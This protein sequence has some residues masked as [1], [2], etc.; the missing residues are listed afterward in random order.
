MTRS[1]TGVQVAAMVLF[2]LVS[3]VILVP[4]LLLFVGPFRDPIGIVSR[5]AIALPESWSLDNFRKVLVDFHFATYFF[6]SI[7]VTVPVVLIS[8]VLAILAG[9]ALAWMRFPLKGPIGILITVVAVMVS[10]Q[11]IMIPLYILMNSLHLVNTFLSVILPQIA[12]SAAVSTFVIRSFFIS[13]PDELVDAS[14]ED[15]ASSWVL[16]WRILVPIATPAILTCA[17]LTTTWTWN[18]FILPVV[19]LPSPRRATLPL[20]LVIFQGGHTIDIPL[21][22]TGALVTALPMLVIFFIFQRHVSRGLLQGVS[23]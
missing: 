2:A 17:T 5:G 19:L 7:I 13:L 12:E 4:I 15:G 1:R 18:D 9:F 21:T 20:G 11:F 23:R 16:L 8:L 22:I 3:A 10:E 6:N 14:L